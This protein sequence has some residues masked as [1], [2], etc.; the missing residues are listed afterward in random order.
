MEPYFNGIKMHDKG[1]TCALHQTNIV[2]GNK[3]SNGKENRRKKFD[4]DENVDVRR[5]FVLPC[6]L[7]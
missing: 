7:K 4:R 2:V 5:F 3:I 6:E 1:E